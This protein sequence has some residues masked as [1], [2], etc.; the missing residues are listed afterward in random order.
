LNKTLTVG[1]EH[2]VTPYTLKLL[3][4]LLLVGSTRYP[5]NCCAFSFL[6]DAV[7]VTFLRHVE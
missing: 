4:F 2:N 3:Q 6:N 7:S 5:E 1:K